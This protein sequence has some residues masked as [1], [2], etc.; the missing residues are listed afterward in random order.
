MMRMNLADKP[1]RAQIRLME[2][3]ILANRFQLASHRETLS[4]AAPAEL[5]AVISWWTRR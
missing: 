5:T 1:R 2:Q 4:G 3:A